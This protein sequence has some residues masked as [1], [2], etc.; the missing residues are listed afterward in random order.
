MTNAKNEPEANRKYQTQRSTPEK[1]GKMVRGIKEGSNGERK[2]RKHK[3]S[4]GV[5]RGS[6]S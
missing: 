3:T 6:K 1:G 4:F 5:L 2:R